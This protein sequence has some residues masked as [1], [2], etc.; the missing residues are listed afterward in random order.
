MNRA[1]ADDPKAGGMVSRYQVGRDGLL[2]HDL[3]VEGGVL[4]SE[5]A[6]LL[7]SFFQLKRK[8]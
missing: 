6:A 8:K 1:C 5:C 3:Q 2:N 4:G 7:K